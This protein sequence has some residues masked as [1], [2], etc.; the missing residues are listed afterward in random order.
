M[1][2]TKENSVSISILFVCSALERVPLTSTEF[3]T[4]LQH[5]RIPVHLLDEPKAR[6]SLTQYSMLI[7]ALMLKTNDEMLGHTSV[8]S[9]VGTLSLLSHWLIASDTL[10]HALNRLTHFYAIVE[11]GIRVDYVHNDELVHITIRNLDSTPVNPFTGEF[12][13]FC[14][15]RIFSWLRKDIIPIHGICFEFDEPVYAR[16]YRLMFYGA[17]VAFNGNATEIS[18]HIGHLQNAVQQNPGALE[19]F[20]RDPISEF[21]MPSFEVTSWA[22]KVADEIKGEVGNL[23]SLPDLADRL[24]LKPYTLQRRLA[25]EG[26]S[27]LT[28]KNQVKRDAAIDLLV[29]SD[30]SIEDISVRLG[31][32][33]VSPFTR[34]FK[35]WT[36]IPPSAYRK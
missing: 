19:D 33:E 9:P 25:E 2:Y 23:P 7:T 14:I 36:G 3:D 24:K 10:M 17:P 18:F 12:A 4:L 35:G 32:S 16:D 11:R 13:F 27:Y 6:V 31:Y 28:I 21:L 22:A 34:S 5:S 1:R 30:L 26:I 20:L 29:N 15:H 8:P